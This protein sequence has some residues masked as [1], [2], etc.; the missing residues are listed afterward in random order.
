[1]RDART[2]GVAGCPCVSCI[3]D[4][5]GYA[6]APPHGAR[7]AAPRHRHVDRGAWSRHPCTLDRDVGTAGPAAAPEPQVLVVPGAPATWYQRVS[8][9]AGSGGG[10]V[11]S[12]RGVAVA[13]RRLPPGPVEVVTVRHL[14]RKRAA[15]TV[16]RDPGPARGRRRRG[17]RG[18]APRWSAPCAT[19]PV[20]PTGSSWPRRSTMP[21]RWPGTLAAVDH[22]NRELARRGRRGVRL[23]AALVDE[24]GPGPVHGQRV[25]VA[26]L[27]LVL[28]LGLPSRC[29][30]TACAT[31]SSWPTSTWPGPTSVGRR[32][33]QPGVPLGQA[34]ARL[35]PAAPT[36]PQAL[37]WDVVEVTWTDVT[38]RRARTG[39]ELVALYRARAV[40]PASLSSNLNHERRQNAD[41]RGTWDQG[42]SLSARARP[43]GRGPARPGCCAGSRTCRPRSSWPAPQEHLAGRAGRPGQAERLGPAHP[44][45]E[46]DHGVRAQQVDAQ[47]VDGHVDLGELELGDRPLGP[48]V[49]GPPVL[50]GPD[51]GEPQDLGLDPQPHQPVALGGAAVATSS[52]QIR[53]A[54][55]MAPT[56]GAGAAPAADGG[57]LVG[58]R[59][60]RHPPALAGVADAVGVGDAHVG[61]VHL[62][63]LGLAGDLAQR[64]HLDARRA[65]R[66]RSRS[67][68]CA[69]GP[70]G[71]CGPPACP[72]RRRGPACSTPSGRSPATRRRRAPPGWRG[73]PGRTRRRAR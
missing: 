34:G 13:P 56:P 66:G 53:T 70:R 52:V 11:P 41:Q 27:R 54:S 43:A 60:H 9:A 1:M 57:A 17:R 6:L 68:P 32:V 5:L 67:G 46:A 33:R 20:A 8:I 73:R 25:R 44:V 61:D 26:V 2:G 63:E 71:R 30:S 69:W 37:G 15:W 50:P 18:G 28:S 39:R 72:G 55:A 48:G 7:P 36:P 51:V 59:R 29:C 16:H 45:V 47:L 24:R 19:W 12:V 31:A 22:R 4:H 64:P 42:R 40:V 35:G 38:E 10:R 62:V 14:R 65:C 23:M 58:Q 21:A 49:A 3:S